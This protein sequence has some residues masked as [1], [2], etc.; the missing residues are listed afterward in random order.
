MGFPAGSDSEE[1]ASNAGDL[2][3]I[4]GWGRSPEGG[5]GNLLQYSCLE[6]PPWIEEPGTLQSIGS[7]R[8]GRDWATKHTAVAQWFSVV[9][10]VVVTMEVSQSDEQISV[11]NHTAYRSPGDCSTRGGA[12]CPLRGSWRPPVPASLHL[13]PESTSPFWARMASVSLSPITIRV[14]L[15]GYLHLKPSTELSLD[16]N[17]WHVVPLPFPSQI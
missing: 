13:L 3:S 11:G 8:V 17:S 14:S 9:V 15:S 7:Q 2:D 6:N 10:V 4:P 5:H 1:S 12:P 16:C